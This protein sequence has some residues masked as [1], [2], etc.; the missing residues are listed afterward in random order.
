M[1]E[2]TPIEAANQAAPAAEAE[3]DHNTMAAEVAAA[4]AAEAVTCQDKVAAEAAAS[5]AKVTLVEMAVSQQ[6]EQAQEAQV[7]QVQFLD[8]HKPTQA[9]VEEVLSQVEVI[10]QAVQAAVAQVD[11][12]TSRLT[13]FLEA[14]TEVVVEDL[15]LTTHVTAEAVDLEW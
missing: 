2:D 10:S 15:D 4:Q 6:V 8:I 11:H 14:P 9:A 1:V 3:A 7:F 13:V 5:Q 12:T